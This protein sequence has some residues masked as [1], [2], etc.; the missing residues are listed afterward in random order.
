[1]ASFSLHPET[2]LFL[3]MASNSEILTNEEVK[4]R[5]EEATRLIHLENQARAQIIEKLAGKKSDKYFLLGRLMEL[6][7]HRYRVRQKQRKKAYVT[8][9]IWDE[10][11]STSKEEELD[12]HLSIKTL[13]YKTQHGSKTLADER[14]IFREMRRANET[15]KE[16]VCPEDTKLNQNQV[17]FAEIQNMRR[18]KRSFDLNVEN[19]KRELESMKNDIKSLE[20]S[21]DGINQKKGEIYASILELKRQNYIL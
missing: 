2:L 8:Q 4:N 7:P 20:N 5:I 1:M 19:L 21:L 16:L 14:R 18:Q 6:L 11:I 3:E 15:G 12:E 13:C 17:T 9:Y 10:K